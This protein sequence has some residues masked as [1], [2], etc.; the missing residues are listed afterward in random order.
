LPPQVAIIKKFRSTPL[1]LHVV[2]DRLRNGLVDRLK[3][4][5]CQAS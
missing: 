2:V 1:R 4:L 5:A 3:S